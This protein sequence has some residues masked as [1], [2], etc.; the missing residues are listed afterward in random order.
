MK[1]FV[2]DALITLDD[3]RM[4]QGENFFLQADHLDL[5]PGRLYMLSGA[6]G[7]GKSTLLHLLALLHP[8][9]SGELRFRGDRVSRRGSQ[10]RRMRQDITLLE[11]S[12]YL[13]SGTVASN[14]ALGLKIR[15]LTAEGRQQRIH[16]ALAAVG[17]SGFEGRQAGQLSG[18]EAR[19]VAL[20]RALALRPRL[21]LL[22]EPTANLDRDHVASFERLI[23]QLP[24]QGICVVMASHDQDQLER[25]GGELIRLEA[26][27]VQ[28][29]VPGAGSAAQGAAPYLPKL[30]VLRCLQAQGQCRAMKPG[31]LDSR[32]AR[33]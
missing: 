10:L 29:P 33:V 16:E 18:G 3:V 26:G 32:A 5:F 2:S 19:R 25:L 22:D 23:A 1:T 14:I 17:L 4:R 8:P 30:R 12:P 31:G 27:R 28:G 7:A 13:F 6:N 24:A 11:Q 9:V 15:G 21:L 20:A